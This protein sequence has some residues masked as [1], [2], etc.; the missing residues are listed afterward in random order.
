MVLCHRAPWRRTCAALLVRSSAL[1]PPVGRPGRQPLS[2]FELAGCSG[3][4]NAWGET[5]PS[6]F[7]AKPL[8]RESN[9][10]MGKFTALLLIY[11]TAG[12][13]LFLARVELGG[14]EPPPRNLPPPW[15]ERCAPGQSRFSS[16]RC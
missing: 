14:I 2:F 6:I 10:W 16:D 7:C 11:K 5:S 9:G 3:R 1:F 8:I 15:S 4:F 13:W 12:R